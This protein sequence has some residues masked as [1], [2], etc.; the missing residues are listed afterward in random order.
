MTRAGPLILLLAG[1]VSAATRDL[2]MGDSRRGR[3]VLQSRNCIACHAVNGA[4][5]SGGPDLART[6]GPGF[7]PFQLAAA[8]WNHAPKMWASLRAKGLR[9]PELSEEE[10]ADVFVYLYSVQFSNGRSDA[11]R[12]R[13]VFRS[14]QCAACHGMERPL[15]E[16]VKPVSAWVAL[17]NPIALARDM[18]NHSSDM[19][20]VL[21]QKKVP[22][23]KLSSR[24]LADLLAYLR[25]ETGKTGPG[26]GFAPGSPERGSNLFAQ[27]GCVACHRGNRSLADR[28]TRYTLLD[29]TA[30][31]WNH[32]FQIQTRAVTLEYDEMRDIIGYVMSAQFLQEKGDFEQGRKVF[33]SKQCGRCHDDPSSGA[34]PREGM[35]GR[36]TSFGLIAAVSRHG[37]AM[38]E[39]MQSKG[40]SWPRFTGLEMADLT[41]YLHGLEFKQRPAMPTLDR[42]G[43]EAK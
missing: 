32:P 30:A 29:L 6:A 11:G 20:A 22:Y 14:K 2:P 21:E 3:E 27:K 16:G 7:S 35:G 37:P 12:G 24:E 4:G 26:S 33:Q 13:A 36:M 17:E 42:G 19:R 10:G 38:I 34:P 39:R 40:L 15:H 31:M 28:S 9:F 43:R 41:T 1:G 23:P 5:G 18:W 25:R 8:L